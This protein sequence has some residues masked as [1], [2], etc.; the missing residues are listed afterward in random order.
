MATTR[1]SDAFVYDVYLSY[2]ALENPEKTAF[3][4]AGVVASSSILNQIAQGAGKVAEVPFWNDLDP[5][6]EPDYTNDDPS[7]MAEPD[8]ITSGN[9]VARKA[10]L[11]KAWSTMLPDVILSEIG[12]AHV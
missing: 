10:F 12:R 11:H 6:I 4:D 9:M 8:K 5:T 2:Q 7:D 1:L 3:W